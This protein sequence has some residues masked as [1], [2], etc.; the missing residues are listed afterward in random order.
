L[1]ATVVAA[2]VPNAAPSVTRTTPAFNANVPDHPTLFRLNVTIPLSV[3]VTENAPDNAPA[4]VNPGVPVAP[5][6]P[7]TDHVWSDDN[8]IDKF[9]S[10]T[11]AKL[12]A[13]FTT[14]PLAPKVSV[15]AEAAVSEYPA[16]KINPVAVTAPPIVIAFPAPAPPNEAISAALNALFAEPSHQFVEAVVH[17]PGPCCAFSV[18][19][20]ESHTN[21]APCT[22]SPV[23]KKTNTIHNDTPRKNHGIERIASCGRF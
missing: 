10:P 5:G 14:I 18:P 12:D 3:F 17:K 22:G 1:F 23:N 21:V 8:A 11:V 16:L 15:C 9:A 13:P 19:A 7:A 6:K 20:S 4:T 2:V